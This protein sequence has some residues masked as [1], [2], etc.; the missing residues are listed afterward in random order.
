[1]VES[2]STKKY[3]RYELV[4]GYAM[5]ELIMAIG[6]FTLSVVSCSLIIATAYSS[7]QQAAAYCQAVTI[8]QQYVCAK[9]KNRDMMD[10]R[11]T[12]FTLLVTDCPKPK[13]IHSN[14]SFLKDDLRSLRLITVSWKTADGFSRSVSGVGIDCL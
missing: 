10:L 3:R 2:D 4:T 9:T 8:L 14:I 11:D 6:V 1:M 7:Y 12:P 13:M 5:I